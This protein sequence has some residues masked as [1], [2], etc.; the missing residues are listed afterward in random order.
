MTSKER[1]LLRSIGSAIETTSQIGKGEIT[2]SIIKDLD[3]QIE[4]R[5]L[6]KAGVL[7]ASPMPAADAAEIL[8]KGLKA[9]I[10]AVTGG[11]ILLYRRSKDDKVKH[12]L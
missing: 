5:E 1:A 7:R 4:K 12:L 10:V 9:E 6:V 3:A 8:A 2:E 11:K